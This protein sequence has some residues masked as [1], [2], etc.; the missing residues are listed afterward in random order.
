M[1]RFLPIVVLL[2]VVLAGSVGAVGSTGN[3][4]EP[5]GDDLLD[6]TTGDD[7]PDGQTIGDET[8]A[9]VCDYADLYAETVDAVVQV[10]VPVFDGTAEEPG[11]GGLGSGFVIDRAGNQYIVTNQ[12]VVAD[13]D[14]VTI[15]FSDG[16]TRDGT[17]IGTDADSDLA[18]VSV[19]DL[20]AGVGSLSFAEETPRPGE[21]VAA[22][23][24]PLGLEGTIT[25]GIVSAVDRSIPTPQGVLIPSAVQTDAPI[26]P[27]NSG[28]PLVDCEGNVVGVN[29]AGAGQN[30][31]FAVGTPLI[32]RVVPSL[33]ETGEYDHAALG[34]QTVDLVPPL[35]AANDVERT[36]GVY[37]DDTVSD[38]PAAGGL[39]GTTAQA[40][41][42]GVQVPVGG[43][44]IVGIDDTEIR[45]GEELNRYLSV[46]A[47][48][49]ERVTLT[50][51]RDGEEAAVTVTLE[52]RSAGD[53]GLE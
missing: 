48:P 51:L 36:S 20:P 46:E 42:S 34:V 26:N 16:Q 50:V 40:T 29:T 43:D 12:H 44:I 7:L 27:G 10:Q 49:G 9:D 52:A 31:G 23:G 5:P 1:Q 47:T 37:V 8:A 30:L 39:Q 28:G 21:R 24:S 32:D 6:Q 17:V 15:E 14:T 41:V 25:E 38:G 35:A 45:N 3:S 4:V 18:I 53:G 33:I 19:S 11:S 2:L 13:E 22:F